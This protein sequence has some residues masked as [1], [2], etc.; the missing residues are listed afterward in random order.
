M[1]PVADLRN[2]ALTSARLTLRS[3]T[4]ADAG[5]AFACANPTVTR[6]MAW[7]PSP[8]PAAFAEVWRGWLPK[9]A[10]GTDLSLVIRLTSAGEFL[11]VAGLHRI[12][13][14]EPEIGIWLKETAHGVG[15]GREAIAAIAA[16][17]AGRIGATAVIYPVAVANRPSRRLAESLGGAVVDTRRLRKP[18]GV[19]LDEVVYRISPAPPVPG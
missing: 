10:A 6:F 12:G 3:F 17:A 14:S 19:V 8:S 4:A 16:W 15:Y 7:D 11:G 2:V 18:S 9:M 5:E 1:T 13:A